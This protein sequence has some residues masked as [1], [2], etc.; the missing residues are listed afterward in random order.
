[1]V[2]C[3][4]RSLTVRSSCMLDDRRMDMCRKEEYL[5]EGKII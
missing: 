4:V 2:S 1:M 5:G 3:M